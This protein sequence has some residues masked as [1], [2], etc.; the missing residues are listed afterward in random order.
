MHN[1]VD[2]FLNQNIEN[3]LKLKRDAFNGTDVELKILKGKFSDYLFKI[4]ACS[5]VNKTISYNSMKY[6]KKKKVKELW[7]ELSLNA[8]PTDFDE[9]KINTLIDEESNYNELTYET[10]YNSE[11]FN[12][13]IENTELLKAISTLTEWQKE[14]VYMCYVQEQTEAK[15]AKKYNVSIQAINKTKNQALRKLRQSMGGD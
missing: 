4:F 13:I 15:V 1:L 2:N 10:D 3:S 9:E 5:Y 11:A 8:M 6:K 7:E 12:L 14:V